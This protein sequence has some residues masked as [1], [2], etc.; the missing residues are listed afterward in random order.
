MERGVGSWED[1]ADLA[2]DWAW[3]G[4]RLREGKGL[5]GSRGRGSE[6]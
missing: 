4:E 5:E 1:E 6:G 2:R 3:A